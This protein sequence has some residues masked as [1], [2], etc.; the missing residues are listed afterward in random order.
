VLPR[1]LLASQECNEKNLLRVGL[2]GMDFADASSSLFL[3]VSFQPPFDSEESQ[4]LQALAQQIA[5]AIENAQLYGAT[6]EMNALLQEIEE[7]KRRKKRSRISPPWC[8]MISDL[9]CRMWCQSRSRSTMACLGRSTSSRIN[10]SGK[11]RPTVEA[12]SSMSVTSW[13]F[14]KSRPGVNDLQKDRRGP[15]RPELDRKQRWKT[16]NDFLFLAGARIDFRADV[17]MEAGTAVRSECETDTRLNGFPLL[18]SES[19]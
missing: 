13:I 14:Q 1:S 15:W 17:K 2:P 9:L 3:L 5:L 8:C 12:S 4:F 11:S 18:G 19:L 7:H 16:H 10:G 6:V